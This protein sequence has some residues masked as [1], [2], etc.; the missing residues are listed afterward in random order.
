[1]KKSNGRKIGIAV[2][3]SGTGSNLKNLINFS[4]KKKQFK[5]KLVVSNKKDAKGLIFAN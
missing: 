5:I 2:F 1:M 3:I 4:K